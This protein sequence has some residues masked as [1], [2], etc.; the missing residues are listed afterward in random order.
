MGDSITTDFSSRIIAKKS[1]AAKCLQSSK[2]KILTLMVLEDNEI[3][4]RDTFANS[5]WTSRWDLT[6]IYVFPRKKMA[7]FDEMEYK[8]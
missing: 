3:M 4:A 5:R 2:Q 1:P 8:K 6:Q 7:V